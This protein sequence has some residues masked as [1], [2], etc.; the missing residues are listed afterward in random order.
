MTANRSRGAALAIWLSLNLIRLFGFG[1]LLWTIAVHG[2][3]L[4]SYVVC[5]S[6][7]AMTATDRRHD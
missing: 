7:A 5:I 4:K 2:I 3:L 6:R 1:I